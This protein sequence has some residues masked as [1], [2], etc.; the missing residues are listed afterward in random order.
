M[1]EVS[2][3]ADEGSGSPGA[4]N[5]GGGVGAKSVLDVPFDGRVPLTQHSL[6]SVQNIFAMTGMF[7]F[8]AILGA[9]NDES[10]QHCSPGPQH[11]RQ[12]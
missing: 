1:E 4:I 9:T 10:R 2:G 7:L 11:D 8:P 3:S 6:M 12:L 5:S